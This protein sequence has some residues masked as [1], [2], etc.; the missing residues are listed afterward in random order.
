[1]LNIVNR[2]PE[3]WFKDEGGRDKCME[4]MVQLVNSSGHLVTDRK[5]PLKLVLKYEN[6]NDVVQQE[7]FKISPECRRYIDDTGSATIKF[8]VEDVSKNH[9]KQSFGIMVAPD[10]ITSPQCADIG[11]ANSTFVDI[12][13]KRNK[14]KAMEEAGELDGLGSRHVR[15]SDSESAPAVISGALNQAAAG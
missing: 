15:F 12:K 9:Q 6:N 14:R 5:V 3:L 8:R 13:S 2:L 4:L 10:V 1:M 11:S 7:L